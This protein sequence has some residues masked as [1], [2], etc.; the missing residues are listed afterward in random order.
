MELTHPDLYRRSS[1]GQWVVRDRPGSFCSVAGDMKVEQTIQRVLK[2][3]G[4]HCVVGETHN[5]GAVAG[6][7]FLFHEG[8]SPA[9]SIF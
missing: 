7:E 6:F 2:D 5:A 8:P 1:I 3:P 9:S 4:G